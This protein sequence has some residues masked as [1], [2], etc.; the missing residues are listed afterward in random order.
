MQGGSFTIDTQTAGSVTLIMQTILPVAIYHD[1]PFHWIIKG[2]TA[3][4]FSPS[5]TYFEHVFCF[6]L[7]SMGIP[8]SVHI[9]KHG[10]YPAG[11]G[12]VIVSTKPAQIKSIEMIER[13]DLDKIK[14]FSIASHHLKEKRVAERMSDGFRKI[15]DHARFETSYVNTRSPGCCVTALATY[16][17]GCC[18]GVSTLGEIRKRAEDVGRDAAR[19]LTDGQKTGACIDSWMVDQI[20]PY[21]AMATIKTK[22]NSKV[23]IPCLTRHAETNID[24][25][26]KFLPVDFD[27][28]NNILTCSG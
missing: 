24:V 16:D 14:V 7:R 28:K 19:H 23:R 15:M 2:G 4:P 22:L 18:I 5:I 6:Y 1:Q 20:I 26:K 27:I 13:G 17:K 8:I 3:V 11:G 25:V 12:E 9:N 21:M 10:F